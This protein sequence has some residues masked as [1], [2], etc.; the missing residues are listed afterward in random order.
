MQRILEVIDKT[1]ESVSNFVCL[2]FAPMAVISVY[3]VIMRYLF[4]RPTIWVW[5][6]NLH[7]FAMIV[8]FGAGNTL[9]KGGH[10]VMDVLIS[11]LSRKTRLILNVFAYVF[12]IFAVGVMAWQTAVFAWRSVV[13][14]ERTS[15]ILAMIVYPLKIGIFCGVTLL[16]LQ[17]I[18]LFIKDLISL[19]SGGRSNDGQ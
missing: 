2:L 5:D 9:R 15:T 6:I 3:E 19:T 16:W 7:L 4:N 13:I 11:H 14:E 8:V 17:G 12:F 10:V 1:N 18:S